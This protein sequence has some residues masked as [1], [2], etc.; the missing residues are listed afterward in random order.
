MS[1]SHEEKQKY[2]YENI[3]QKDYNPEEFVDFIKQY[4]ENGENI[5]NWELEELKK[6]VDKFIS[7]DKNNETITKDKKEDDSKGTNIG[8]IT[9]NN[10]VLYS[11]IFKENNINIDI[12][13]Y[14]N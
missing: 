10:N 2:L 9:N 8:Y 3:I 11:P 6:I 5:E 12:I 1:N 13:E 14:Y 4:K 7:K